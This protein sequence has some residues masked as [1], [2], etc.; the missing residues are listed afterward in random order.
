M[1]VKRLSNKEIKEINR[2]LG[3]QFTK[4]DNLEIIETE[5]YVLLTL[6][7]EPLYFKFEDRWIP[8]L[9]QLL[10]KE[11][12]RNIIVDK[13]AIRF[14]VNG[15]D[16]MRPGI[17]RWDEG[18]NKDEYVVIREET[19]NKPLAVGK[20]MVSGEELKTIDKGKVIKNIHHVGD[21]IWEFKG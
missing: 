4:K 13:G 18:I 5:E 11:I 14:V 1:K 17:V 19:H 20:M 7:R 3:E 8:T 15:A 6:N 21:K 10:N 12:L 16:I 9:K 2:E